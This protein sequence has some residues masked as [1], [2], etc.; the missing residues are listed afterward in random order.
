MGY[1]K[2]TGNN[3]LGIAKW[4]IYV[5]LF[6]LSA[7]LAAGIITGSLGILAEFVH[8]AF[9]L[10]ASV[11]A[12]LGIKK[13]AQPADKTHHYGHDRFENISSLLQSI[14]I[15][16]T[17]FIIIYEA[18]GKLNGSAHI[19]K[20]SALGIA[21]MGITLVLDIYIARYLHKKSSETGSPALEA[22]AYHFTTDILSTIAVIIGLAAASL[23]YPVADVISA[24]IVALIMFYISLRLGK[25]AVFV[26]LDRA[27]DGKVIE[28]ISAIISKYPK[29]DGYHSL[30]ARTSG[31]KAF[32]DVC[33]HL[34]ESLSLD[35]AH[36]IAEA[37][38]KKIIAECPDVKEVVIHLEPKS[39]HD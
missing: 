32:I 7:K 35:A 4:S 14:L 24:I 28:E 17:S 8:S 15:T 30:R 23:G 18:Y 29:V 19:V 5:N 34:D 12:Y 16:L 22:D 38:E 13:A 9:D 31:N 36:K 33:V 10:L 11:F 26:M 21:V 37:L 20:E 2:E 3:K 39:S 25:D 6:L 1:D 27:P